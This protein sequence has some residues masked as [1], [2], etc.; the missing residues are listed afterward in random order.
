[1]EVEKCQRFGQTV[2]LESNSGGA[3]VNASSSNGE[4]M[5]MG[6]RSKGQP[7]SLL[8]AWRSLSSI[9]HK[10]GVGGLTRR[11]GNE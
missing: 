6:N 1:M 2:E 8:L 9:D 3:D 4:R 11:H 7:L 5:R 10:F